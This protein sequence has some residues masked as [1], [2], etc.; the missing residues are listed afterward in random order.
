MRIFR[1]IFLIS[2]IACACAI[3][4]SALAK[5]FTVVLDPGHGG[6]DPGTHGRTA[7]E[8]T[9][10]LNISN[11]VKRLLSRHK[12]IDAQATRTTDTY[13]TLDGRALK[14]NKSLCDLFVSIHCNSLDERNPRRATYC[15]ATVYSMSM[16]RST[17][18]LE[19][20]KK[21]NSVVELDKLY[22]PQEQKFASDELAILA[23]LNQTNNIHHSVLAA[24]LLQDELV[25]TGG[26]RDLGTKKA[27]FL[28]LRK[29]TRPAVLVEVDY[30]CNPTVEQF[31][32]SEDGQDKI[33]K[34]LYNGI[35]AYKNALSTDGAIT[36]PDKTA[37]AGPQP[38]DQGNE[39]QTEPEREEFRIQFLT[40]PRQLP[41]GSRQFKGLSPAEHYTEGTTVKY[42]Y[43]HFP[44]QAE[45]AK[46]LK[47]V[48]ALFPDAF[49][50]RWANGR[51]VR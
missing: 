14:A 23:E 49:I 31:L 38:D 1:F 24:N 7:K 42:T 46:N 20:V 22:A 33:A 39:P 11:K 26:R 19:I 47:K 32:D 36:V 27:G 50:I 9:V 6:H 5:D 8:K 13:V 37:A 16:E 34:A 21:E 43:G 51:R 25:G 10:A 35:I 41:A 18:N 45:A 3:S 4:P 28:V 2:A 17:E 12:D 30:L 44:T 29:T 40:A 15:G 48:K